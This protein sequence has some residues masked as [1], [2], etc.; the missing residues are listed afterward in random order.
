MLGC[1][2]RQGAL[3][4][5]CFFFPVC[6]VAFLLFSFSLPILSDTFYTNNYLL[7]TYP[8]SIWLKLYH[9]IGTSRGTSGL[10]PSVPFL[11]TN[12][13]EGKKG[14]FFILT[15]IAKLKRYRKIQSP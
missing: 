4:P 7:P 9:K 5:V 1:L 6:F 8:P 13:I 15:I 12:K 14:H 10:R 2:L 3:W 11:P